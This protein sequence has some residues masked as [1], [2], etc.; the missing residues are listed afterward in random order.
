MIIRKITAI[1]LV[2]A[3]FLMT[4]CG[5]GNNSSN[6]QGG[7]SGVNDVLEQGKKQ[8]DDKNNGVTDTPTP[9]V[10]VDDPNPTEGPVNPGDG[11]I[12]VDLTTMSSTMIYAE[13]YNMLTKPEEYI[14]KKIKINGAF[15]VAHD[16]TTGNYYYL[17]VIKDAT[18]CCAQGMEFLPLGTFGYP[19]NCPE[20]GT[21]ITVVGTFS[22]YMEGTTMYCTLKEATMS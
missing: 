18:A 20:I 9:T 19:D 1:I 12:D 7:S 21:E 5:A 14:G 2:V 22:T 15:A 6:R 17:C 8:E 13:V 3:M 10:P 11:T 16:E 4:G